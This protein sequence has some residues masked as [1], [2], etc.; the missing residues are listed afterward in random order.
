MCACF[1]TDDELRVLDEMLITPHIECLYDEQISSQNGVDEVA[2]SSSSESECDEKCKR[3]R[4]SDCDDESD[5]DYVTY[6]KKFKR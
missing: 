1:L 3:K 4:C 6:P 5:D 2:P